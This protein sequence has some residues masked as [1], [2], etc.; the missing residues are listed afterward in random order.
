MNVHLIKRAAT[1][2]FWRLAAAGAIVLLLTAVASAQYCSPDQCDECDLCNRNLSCCHE[3]PEFWVINTRCSPKCRNLDAGF[4]TLSYKRWDPVCRRWVKE[5]RESLLAQE[6]TKPTMFFSHGNTLQHGPAMESAWDV[7]H[8]LRCCPGPKRLVFW[9]WPSQIAF[10][11][12]LLRPRQLILKNLRIKFVYAEYQG[13]YMAKLVQHMSMSQRVMLAG[14]SYG[15][16]S[17]ATAAHWL[18]GGNLRGLTLDGGSPEEIPNLRLGMVS[19]AF[20]NDALIPGRR[21][22][23]AFVAAEKIYVTRN[24]RDKTLDSWLGISPRNRPAIG[25]TGINA[26][27]LGQYRDKLCQQ[28]LTADVGRSHYLGPHLEST[29]FVASLCCLA[30]PNCPNCVATSSST[31]EADRRDDAPAI[32]MIPAGDE[33]NLSATDAS[34]EREAQ[35]ADQQ[36]ADAASTEN[37][38]EKTAA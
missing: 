26:N 3:L 22:G 14:H 35:G 12:P 27:L 30:F 28:T 6:A 20:D 25:V 5:S 33:Q 36:P 7:Y 11:R 13:Y 21:Y 31:A 34:A 38:H 2:A 19:G 9:S 10:K 23:Q 1:W 15:A 4:E 37:A 17:A 29:R 18:G 32:L 24:G 16:I 8:R